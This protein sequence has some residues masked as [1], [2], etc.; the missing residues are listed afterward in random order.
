LN[1][2]AIIY[3]PS[4]NL[5][6]GLKI[7]S[8]HSA[9]AS[10]PSSLWSD[11]EAALRNLGRTLANPPATATGL[12]AIALDRDRVHQTSRHWLMG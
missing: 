3:G 10:L 12:E 6:E 8:R 11:V 5:Y 9:T 1:L 7:M 2:Q 4:Q